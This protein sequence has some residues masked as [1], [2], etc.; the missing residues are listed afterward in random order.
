MQS[1]NVSMISLLAADIILILHVLFAAFVV[2]GL[3][4]IFLGKTLGWS[5]VRNPWFRLV[6]VGAIGV[7]TLESWFGVACPL[8]TWEKMLRSQVGDVVYTGS[9]L[10]HLLETI[11]YYR[12]PM[13]VFA[14]CYTVFG[15]MVLA[16][17]IWIRPRPF[18]KS[19]KQG[20]P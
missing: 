5:W 10:S 19:S 14:V 6:H 15:M 1:I 18:T 13:W 17:W 12:A 9:F 16:G 20:N 11:L 7:V 2:F 3:L 4:L 8:T